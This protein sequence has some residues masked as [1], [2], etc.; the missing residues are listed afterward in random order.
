M[1]TKILHDLV[2]YPKSCFMSNSPNGKLKD[3]IISEY[4]F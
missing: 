4:T 1:Y 3:N 2:K